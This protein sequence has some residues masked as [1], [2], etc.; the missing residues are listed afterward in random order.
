MPRLID[1]NG[2]LEARAVYRIIGIMAEDVFALIQALADSGRAAAA[3]DQLVDKFRNE[4]NYAL[5]F[6]A[7]L[8]RKRHQL[9]LPLIQ[10]E[11][12]SALPDHLRRE[13]E[14]EMVEA[15][16]ETGSLY[17]AEGDIERAWPYFRAISEPEAVR[18]AIERLEPPPEIDGIV[19]IAFQEGVH[20]AKGLEL[21]LKQYG[22][23]RALTTF[24]MYAVPRDRDACIRLLVRSL[25]A[26]LA[27]S[28]RRAIENVEGSA[29]EAAGVSAL[30]AERDWLF[31][32]YASYVDTSHLAS[33]IRYAIDLSDRETLALACELCDYGRRLSPEFRLRSEPPF[34]DPYTDYDLYLR[35]LLGEDADRAV[36]HFRRKAAESD[37]EEAGT[38]PAQVLVSLLCRLRR[39]GEAVEVSLEHLRGISPNELICPTALQLCHLAGDYERLM[40]LAR[41]R[42]DLLSYAAAALARAPAGA[43]RGSSPPLPEKV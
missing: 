24:G 41:E 42:G 31:G 32:E 10:T 12:A 38:M 28:L 2:S 43:T 30:I 22:I 15:A 27:D 39:Y 40:Q 14:R 9:G 18:D 33:V 26:E 1:D 25:Y 36:E 29:P 16:R 35:A 6:E 21:I 34:E 7:R 13:Y 5:L 37:P 20:P 3:F 4:K 11:D 19:Q 8:M 23:C 17:L